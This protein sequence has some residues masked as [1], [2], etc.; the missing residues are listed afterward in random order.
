M[1]LEIERRYLLL[2]LQVEYFL[3]MLNMQFTKIDITQNYVLRDGKMGRVRQ[4]NDKYYLTIKKGEGLVREEFEEE[5]TPE[6]Y[7]NVLA[8]E[9]KIN[10]LR[11]K[12]YIVTIDGFVYEIDEFQG[13]LKGLV[14]LEVEFK[15]K[16]E[17]SSFTMNKK[18]QKVMVEE[19]TEDRM[20][21]NASLAA[22]QRLPYL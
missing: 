13:S 22:S 6:I 5:I 12:R 3:R 10:T 19:V 16:E 20:F 2:P 9:D 15:N 1:A 11:K 14:L 8:S 4:L 17:A 7:N 21:D 18:M